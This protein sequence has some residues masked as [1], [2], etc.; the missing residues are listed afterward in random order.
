MRRYRGVT[1]GST[2]LV[3]CRECRASP[4]QGLLLANLAILGA[5]SCPAHATGPGEKQVAASV[6]FALAGGD[7]SAHPGMQASVEAAL[8]FTDA[9]A[10]RGAVSSSWQAGLGPRHVTAVSLGAVYSLDVV[11]WV[12]FLDLGFSLA[13]LRG[14]G[15]SSQRLGPQLGWAWSTSSRGAGPWQPWRF[16]DYCPAPQGIWW[17]PPLVGLRRPSHRPGVLTQAEWRQRPQH[18]GGFV[19]AGP[20]PLR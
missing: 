8:G 2:D 10:G 11:R 13:D 4:F 12:P 16:S 19:L 20:R 1:V 5:V 6:G 14:N 18:H 3:H 9:W 15:A 17:H 7:D